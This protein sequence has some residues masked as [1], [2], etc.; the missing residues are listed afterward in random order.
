VQRSLFNLSFHFISFQLSGWAVVAPSCFAELHQIQSLDCH[1]Q[2]QGTHF[3]KHHYHYTDGC[4]SPKWR[5]ACLTHFLTG[6]GIRLS[7][8]LLMP[9]QA[10]MHRR[11]HSERSY[12]SYC[13]QTHFSAHD[14]CSHV[15]R[16]GSMNMRATGSIQTF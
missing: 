2:H 15:L 11:R 10:T 6:C 9:V 14:N 16:H 3:H 4:D 13:Q 7:D 5:V 8:S 12:N 1:V